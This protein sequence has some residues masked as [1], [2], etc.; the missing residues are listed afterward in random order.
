MINASLGYKQVQITVPTADIDEYIEGLD[1][2][3]RLELLHKIIKVLPP[4]AVKDA[5]RWAHG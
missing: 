1:A 5:V 4:S 2:D 3:E